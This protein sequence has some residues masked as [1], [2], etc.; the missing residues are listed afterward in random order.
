MGGCFPGKLGF[1]HGKHPKNIPG[2]S[3]ALC[4]L[5][6]PNLPPFWVLGC[7]HPA[8]RPAPQRWSQHSA[9]AY[10]APRH[11]HSP[12][13]SS[14]GSA[15]HPSTH[16]WGRVAPT[17]I[18]LSP[19]HAAKVSP[20]SWAI[21]LAVCK[22]EIKTSP[23]GGCEWQRNKKIKILRRAFIPAAPRHEASPAPWGSRH[24]PL[25]AVATSLP[26]QGVPAREKRTFR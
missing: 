4:G 21:V 18:F 6:H 16:S 3:C 20:A 9:D 7:W 26:V 8:S 12:E 24:G 11:H 19:I 1:S 15:W 25:G 22:K 2:C 23:L 10:R 5:P 17:A 13:Q 14:S